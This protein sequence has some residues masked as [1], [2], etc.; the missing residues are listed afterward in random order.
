M[1]YPNGKQ[2]NWV[3]WIR[4]YLTMVVE[5]FVELNRSKMCMNSSSIRNLYTKTLKL[6]CLMNTQSETNFQRRNKIDLKFHACCTHIRK[7]TWNQLELRTLAIKQNQHR[8][9]G[10]NRKIKTLTKYN[11]KLKAQK[12]WMDTKCSWQSK[13][14]TKLSKRVE[15]IYAWW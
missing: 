12:W 1:T 2:Q 15:K 7:K 8:T 13:H 11:W 3:L 6:S 14:L 4:T 9:G 10:R 5:T